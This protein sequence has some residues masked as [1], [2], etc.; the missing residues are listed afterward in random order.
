MAD[1]FGESREAE[2]WVLSSSSPRLG[3]MHLKM[4]PLGLNK[5]AEADVTVLSGYQQI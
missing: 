2:S 4:I 3:L 5:D 1:Q